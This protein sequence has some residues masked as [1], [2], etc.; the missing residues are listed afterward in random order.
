MH[1]N[2]RAMSI[3]DF[4]SPPREIRELSLLQELERNPVISQRELSEKFGIALGVTNACLKRMVLNGWIRTRGS[5]DRKIGYYITPKGFAEKSKLNLHVAFWR[6]QH[7]STLKEMIGKIFFQMERDRI[8][9]IVF[10]GVSEEMEIAY[11]AL[12]GRNLKLVGI[13]EDDDQWSSCIILGYELEPVSRV[14]ALKPDCILITSFVENDKK[15]ES[16][17]PLIENQPV[18]IKELS[19]LSPPRG[20]W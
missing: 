18:P 13:V 4:L 14:L 19:L 12:Q 20:G 10:Y 1:Q 16:L 9:R 3:V 2:A 7:Y 8:E 6:V 5:D 11:I 15:R 17:A